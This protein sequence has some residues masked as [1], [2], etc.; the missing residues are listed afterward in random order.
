MSDR[1][2]SFE[3]L[4]ALAS[5]LRANIKKLVAEVET[6]RARGDADWLAHALAV[7]VVIRMADSAW[8]SGNYRIVECMLDHWDAREVK[9]GV[10][11]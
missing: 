11:V 8:C 3:E 6:R 1:V 10:D 2:Y 5:R 9:G 7:G 4:R